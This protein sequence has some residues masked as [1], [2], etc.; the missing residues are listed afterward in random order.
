MPLA[1][2][3]EVLAHRG[4]P[5]RMEAL[6]TAHLAQLER[7]LEE[8]RRELS[9]I[10]SLLVS[11]ELTMIPTT[12]AVAGPEL[13]SALGAV[14]FAVSADPE[15]PALGGVLFDVTE[16]SVTLVATDRYRL[17]VASV[18]AQT[19]DGAART[20]LVPA[21]LADAIVATEAPQVQL[22]L[23]ADTITV[24]AGAVTVEGKL[25]P[26]TFPDYRRLL[27]AEN[28]PAVP[29]TTQ[30][31]AALTAPTPRTMRREQDGASYDVTILTTRNDGQI[32]VTDQ[33]EGIGVN[34]EFLLEALDADGEGQ[35][36]LSLDGPIAPLVIRSPRSVSLLM[37]VRL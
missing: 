4:D 34:R 8:A 31:R 16:G 27:P 29:I 3:R 30:L 14:R 32:I 37:P 26:D 23:G 10:R 7:G 36:E 25:I 33:N 20:V 22:A 18:P 11:Q 17:A 9:A 24:H 12:V 21:A 19:S 6:L 5:G 35:L 2:I 28:A 1:D 13:A 15:L